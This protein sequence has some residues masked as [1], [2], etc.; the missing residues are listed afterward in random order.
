MVSPYPK[1]QHVHYINLEGRTD[2]KTHVEQQ[3]KLV[4]LEAIRFNAIQH[5]VGAIG[6]AMSHLELLRMAKQNKFDH[7]LIVEDDIEFISPSVF[8]NSL[9][10]FLS[11]G[12][13]YDVLMLAGNNMGEYKMVDI[14]CVQIRRC[15]TTTGYIVRHHYYDRLIENIEKGIELYLANPQKNNLYAIDV[16]WQTLQQQ[17]TWYLLAP[18][19]VIQK[20]DY[21]DIEKKHVNYTNLMLQ[22]NKTR[23]RLRTMAL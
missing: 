20:P 14:T 23:R 21:S 1:I 4:G 9:S 3:M 13:T 12:H 6:C 10:R 18:L 22:L 8:Q 16:F 11:S 7:I 2:R 19:S 17:D 15:F 5:E